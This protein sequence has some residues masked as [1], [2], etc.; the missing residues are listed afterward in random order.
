MYMVGCAKR[1]MG[2]R[3]RAVCRRILPCHLVPLCDGRRRVSSCVVRWLKGAEWV[4]RL[5]M[6]RGIAA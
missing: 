4:R 3:K 6:L 2:E 5:Y 1:V